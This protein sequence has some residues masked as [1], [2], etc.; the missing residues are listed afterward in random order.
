[1]LRR[2]FMIATLITLFIP[3]P[4]THANPATKCVKDS[5]SGGERCTVSSS[6]VEIKHPV[7]PKDTNTRQTCSDTA[8][9]RA[10]DCVSGDSWWHQDKQCY[11]SLKQPQP[12]KSERI[13]QGKTEGVIMSC[14]K[15]H[16]GS[17]NSYDFWLPNS[18]PAPNPRVLAEQAIA[19]MNLLPVQI[20]TYPSSLSQDPKAMGVVGRWVWLWAKNPDE[21]TWGPITRTATAAGH[22]VTATAKVSHIVWNM[23]DGK[24]HTCR[25]AGTPWKPNSTDPNPKSPTCS[26]QYEKQGIQTVTATSHWQVTWSGIGQQGTITFTLAS[27][28][29]IAIGELHVL[30][31]PRPTP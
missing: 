27:T 3:L 4:N 13:W 7:T 26:Y 1:M 6:H 23:G 10:V 14:Q 31:V 9:G 22:S 21:H 24:N 28:A 19:Q 5:R 11:V 2:I 18:K 15:L 17:I 16:L 12:D 30:N 29:R 25:N 20:G 8:T